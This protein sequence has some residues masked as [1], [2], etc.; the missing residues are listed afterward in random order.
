MTGPSDF[1]LNHD[2]YKI[3]ACFAFAGLLT[4]CV[5]YILL[6]QWSALKVMSVGGFQFILIF[7]YILLC[8]NFLLNFVLTFLF[9]LRNKKYQVTN[10]VKF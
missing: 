5:L 2:R 6:L 4:L 1:F 10:Y 9:H 3:W 7:L 8:L